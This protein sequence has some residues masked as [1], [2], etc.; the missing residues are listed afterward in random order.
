MP[1]GMHPVNKVSSSMERV[2]LHLLFGLGFRKTY[3]FKYDWETCRAL[4][5]VQQFK[6]LAVIKAKLYFETNIQGDTFLM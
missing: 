5:V 6:M 3:Y 4:Q 1:T 2:E